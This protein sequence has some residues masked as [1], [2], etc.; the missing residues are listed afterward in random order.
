M[1]NELVQRLNDSDSLI[2]ILIQMEDFLDGLD[3]Y[4]FKN[5]IDGEVIDGPRLDR[6][7]VSMT[8]QY[9]YKDMPDPAGAERLIKYGAMIEYKKTTAPDTDAKPD[10][11][12][13]VV[14]TAL[15][16]NNSFSGGVDSRNHVL[17]PGS[18]P[19][20][21]AQMQLPTKKVWRIKVKIPRHFIEEIVGP[22]IGV[23]TDDNEDP[24]EEQDA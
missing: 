9:D 14:N 16:S 12:P 4:A 18:Q 8:L 11:T 17:N 21:Q 20:T 23:T 19:Q 24:T 10:I 7:W 1:T 5:W 13:Q 6:H 3:I 22:D 15:N 2:D